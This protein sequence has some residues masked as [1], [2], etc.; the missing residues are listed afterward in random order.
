[1]GLFLLGLLAALLPSVVLLVW[2]AWA[3]GAFSRDVTW[4]RFPPLSR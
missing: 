1:M 2:L 4:R 3:S